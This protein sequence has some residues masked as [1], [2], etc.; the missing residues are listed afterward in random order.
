MQEIDMRFL[1]PKTLQELM[2]SLQTYSNSTILAGGTDLLVRIRRERIYPETIISLGALGWNAFR[3]TDGTVEIDSMVTAAQL[4]AYDCPELG[5]LSSAAS[6]V[7]GAQIRNMATIGGNVVNASPAADMALALVA[8]DADVTI[9][10]PEGERRIHLHEFLRGP[11]QTTLSNVEVVRS[12]HIPVN[13]EISVHWFRKV[14]PRSRH[15]ISRV[16]LAAVGCK[17]K[18]RISSIRI[19]LGS[20]A[21][22]PLRAK[23]AERYLETAERIGEEEIE[24]AARMASTEDC[25]PISDHRSSEEYRRRIVYNIV[26]EFLRECA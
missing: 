25:K 15:F 10:G 1:S 3:R 6:Q 9:V 17:T 16:A 2:A 20:V 5:V 21:P 22:V 23:H 19:A 24:T 14:G 18:D 13:N 4:L 11:G 7:G 12:F 8:L 26:K